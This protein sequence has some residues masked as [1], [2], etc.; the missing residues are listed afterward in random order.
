MEKLLEK[1]LGEGYEVLEVHAGT[2]WQDGRMAL[3][4]DVILY[5]MNCVVG[6]FPGGFCVGLLRAL[7]LDPD[8]PESLQVAQKLARMS[9]DLLGTPVSPNGSV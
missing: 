5:Q 8:R 9:D 4:G 1:V 7:G 6:I 3:R 2:R